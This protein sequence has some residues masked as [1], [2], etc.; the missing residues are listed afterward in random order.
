MAMLACSGVA[1]NTP[2]ISGGVGFFADRNA[3]ANT[4]QPVLA[5]VIAAPLGHHLLVESR[6][7]LRESVTDSS[8]P[9]AG[10]FVASLQY[11]QLDYIVNSK[12]TLVGGK[13]LTPFGTYNERLTALWVPYLQNA[14]LLY[15]I[16]T[17]TSGS[18]N[19]GMVRGAV[20][21]KPKAQLNY[22]AYFSGSSQLHELKAARTAGTQLAVYFP[23]QR[24]EI[25]TSY[26]RFL[27]GVHNDS[28]GMH[29]WWTPAHSAFELRSE[30]AHGARSQGYWI[31]MAYRLSR[32]RGPDSL[33]GRFQPVLRMQQTFRNLANYPGQGDGLPGVDTQQIDFGFDY[34]LPH[35]IR[36]N[37]SYARSYTVAKNKNIWDLS[38]SHRFLFPVWRGGK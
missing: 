30:Y 29:V 33:V 21:S 38:I 36:L 28:V 15:G 2:L 24:L 17:R 26:Q 14:P 13:F 20:I 31:E 1:Q 37:S 35:E 32:V 9:Y 10:Q 8:S 5:P 6:G 19:G 7:D 12:L 34:H 22:I 4:F 23:E 16:G 25:G 3:G 18:S 11:L 27:E